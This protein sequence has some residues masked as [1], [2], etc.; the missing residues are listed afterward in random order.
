MHF[1][2]SRFDAARMHAVIEHLLGGETLG[3]LLGQSL[4]SQETM[5]YV[6][7]TLYGQG[8]FAEA[9]RIFTLLVLCDHLDR[10]YH[11][12]LAAC[13]HVQKRHADAVKSYRAASFLDQTDPEPVMHLAECH[14]AL[15]EH[16][17]AHLAL[18]YALVQAR[19]HKEHRHHV[20][21][22]E[23]L[24]KLLEG[25]RTEASGA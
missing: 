13:L 14:L 10:R 12:G 17:Q 2:A 23:A 1:D 5:Y 24:L 6:G 15:G 25:R 3:P 7:H 11:M 20:P 21:R 19:A 22:V 8:K 16:E 4:E 18:N 9:A